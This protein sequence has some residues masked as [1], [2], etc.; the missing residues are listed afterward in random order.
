VIWR[1]SSLLLKAL[2][3]C[4]HLYYTPMTSIVY[5]SLF[6]E[7][8]D[9]TLATCSPARDVR[10]SM[11]RNGDRKSNSTRMKHYRTTCRAFIPDVSKFQGVFHSGSGGIHASLSRAS[12]TTDAID[13]DIL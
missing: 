10:Q 5:Q 11:W 4:E 2:G 3:G 6:N 7:L 1:V 13:S 12:E 9:A 8:S